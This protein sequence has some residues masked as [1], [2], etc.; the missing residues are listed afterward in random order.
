M[1]FEKSRLFVDLLFS[2]GPNASNN[3][4]NKINSNKTF[5]VIT[6]T[7]RIMAQKIVKYQ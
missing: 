6:G 1:Q 5:I 4:N 7:T 2:V 3:N